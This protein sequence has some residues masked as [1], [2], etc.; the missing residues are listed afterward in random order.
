MAAISLIGL[1]IWGYNWT[2]ER[3]FTAAE[4]KYLEEKVEAKQQAIAK[5]ESLIELVNGLAANNIKNQ[6]A[7][8]DKLDKIIDNSKKKP[9]TNIPCTPN[10]NFIDSWNELKSAA[11]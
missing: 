5:Y 1:G 6:N 3:G 8:E 4:V 11:K 2:Y 7:V 9:V 10:Q